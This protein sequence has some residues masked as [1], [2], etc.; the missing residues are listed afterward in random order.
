MKDA[1]THPKPT[2]ASEEDLGVTVLFFGALRDEVSTSKEGFPLPRLSG[3]NAASVEQVLSLVWEKYP[4]LREQLPSL[5]FAVN[6]SFAEPK[7]LIRHGDRL[8]L[9]PPLTGG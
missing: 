2:V 5:R 1:H 7:T 3:G 8:A 9:L 6:E 4:Q